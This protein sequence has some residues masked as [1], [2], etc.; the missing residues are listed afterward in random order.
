MANELTVANMGDALVA[1]TISAQYEL[2]V[3]DRNSFLS[4]PVI[5]AGYMGAINGKS[6]NVLSK[7]VAG[8]GGYDPLQ[9]LGDGVAPGNSI[10]A[11]DKLSATITKQSKVYAGHTDLVKTLLEGRLSI[12]DFVADASMSQMTRL[13]DM[14][15]NVVDGY[16]NPVG[17][18]GVDLD[19]PTVIAAMT[20]ARLR[21]LMGPYLLLIHGQQWGDVAQD[22]ALAS[23]GALQWLPATADLIQLRGEGYQGNWLGMDVFVSNRV[24]TANAGA[25]RAGA[26]LGTTPGGSSVVWGDG[27]LAA[28]LPTQ[29]SIAGK[30]LFG[31]SRDEKAGSEDYVS[32]A[33]L[34]ADVGQDGVTL[35][36]D[37]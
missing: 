3:S 11:L 36:S 21:N 37:A 1:E 2:K 12:A 23:G 9:S 31:I 10:L 18:T 25:D 30:I 15:A 16:T 29:V 20:S 14:L 22:A 17:S 35:I 34:G 7:T 19:V 27:D 4:H 5:K 8:L 28:T 32:H 6:S 13:C 24:V 33:L 26:L